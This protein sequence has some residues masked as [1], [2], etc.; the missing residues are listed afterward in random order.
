M[1]R[2]GGWYADCTDVDGVT[3]AL[4]EFGDLP[5]V[6]AD[7][8]QVGQLFQNL[9]GNALKFTVPGRPAVVQVSAERDGQMIRFRVQDNGIGIEE[10]YHERIFEAFRRLHAASDYPGS[11]IGLSIV[12]R[13]CALYGWHVR[14]VP[15]DERGV[16]ATLAFTPAAAPGGLG[17]GRKQA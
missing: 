11:G 9:I 8:T 3:G 2:S 16:V 1:R 14:V 13:L 10:Q 7:G 5:A 4:A 15:G 12:R 17:P 6:K